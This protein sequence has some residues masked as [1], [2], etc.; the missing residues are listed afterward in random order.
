LANA[1]TQPRSP[2]LSETL[3]ELDGAVPLRPSDSPP[4]VEEG[5]GV[6]NDA[7]DEA[8]GAAALAVGLGCCSVMSVSACGCFTLN[9]WPG[10]ITSCSL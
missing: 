7:R 4:G 3:V 8:L 9:F 10:R 6:G 5:E 1:L 2:P